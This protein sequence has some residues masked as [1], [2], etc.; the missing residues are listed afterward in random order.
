ME[1]YKFE[2]KKAYDEKNYSRVDELLLEAKAKNINVSSILS[3]TEEEYVKE[4]HINLY[5][6]NYTKKNGI[7]TYRMMLL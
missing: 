1:Y 6:S 5:T 3:I 4:K 7:L 2:T